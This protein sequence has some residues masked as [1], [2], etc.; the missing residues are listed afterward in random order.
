MDGKQIKE[1]RKRLGFTQVQL[2]E[3]LNYS[4]AFINRLERGTRAVP[5]GFAMQLA[6]RLRETAKTVTE[7]LTNEAQSIECQE[8]S[9]N[10]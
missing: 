9:G 8:E 10:N 1:M 7:K 5:K 3:I 6:K 2:S 4:P